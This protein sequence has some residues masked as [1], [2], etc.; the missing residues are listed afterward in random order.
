MTLQIEVTIDDYVWQDYC[1][2]NKVYP[3][4]PTPDELEFFVDIELN[5]SPDRVVML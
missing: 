4:N 2:N 1:E 3:D 5:I